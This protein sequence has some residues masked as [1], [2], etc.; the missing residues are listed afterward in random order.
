MKPTTRSR[1]LTRPV[2]KWIKIGSVK[3]ELFEDINNRLGIWKTINTIQYLLFFHN[4]K[5]KATVLILWGWKGMNCFILFVTWASHFKYNLQECVFITLPSEEYL[6]LLSRN[7]RAN[8]GSI[9]SS[10][11]FSISFYFNGALLTH[12]SPTIAVKSLSV[13]S[14]L[15]PIYKTYQTCSSSTCTQCSAVW[16]TGT[17]FL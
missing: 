1:P 4:K 8:M 11:S 9:F 12:H 10:F 6:L 17:L 15:N 14:Q 13:S 7:L 3:T 2:V 5:T 16:F